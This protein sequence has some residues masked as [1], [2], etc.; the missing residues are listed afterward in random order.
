MRIVLLA[1]LAVT[2]RLAGT[3][4]VS[5]VHVVRGAFVPGSQPDGNSVIFVGREG[6]MVVDTGRH[7]S[8]PARI[9]TFARQVKRPVQAVINTH[10]LSITSAAMHSWAASFPACGSTPAARS[11]L[12]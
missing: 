2:P 11:T 6:V 7:V 4:V 9:S 1:L 10:W 12:R 3:E 5:G 8:H